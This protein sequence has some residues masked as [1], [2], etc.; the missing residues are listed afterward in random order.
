VIVWYFDCSTILF[1]R[2]KPESAPRQS[3]IF[4]LSQRRAAQPI[5]V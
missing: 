4:S 5:E 3:P 1:K 2:L